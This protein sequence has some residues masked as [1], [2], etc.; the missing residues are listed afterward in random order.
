MPGDV[1]SNLSLRDR[2]RLAGVHPKLIDSL[3]AIFGELRAADHPMFVVQGVRTAAQQQALYAQGRT[4]PGK[5]VTY[6]DGVIHKSNHQP[7]ADG[8]G[9][10]VD[11]AFSGPMPFAETHPWERYGKLVEA[12]GLKWGGRWGMKDLPHVELV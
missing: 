4:T 2:E 5:I 12:H 1:P 11:C 9:H 8:L 6:K 3:D 7:H 10:A